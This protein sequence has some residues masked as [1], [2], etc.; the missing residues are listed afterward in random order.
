MLTDRPI[1]VSIP[2]ADVAR[3]KRFFAEQ[4][5][6][7]PYSEHQYGVIYHSGGAQITIVGQAQAAGQAQYSLM[8]WL[9]EDIEATVATLRARGV[10]F[11]EYDFD[12]PN[13]HM[14][15]GIA[16]IEED[17]VAW[18]KDSEGNLLA[19]AQMAAD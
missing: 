11:E 9:V 5:G 2:A 1:R 18:F 17:R 3:A 6:L 15:D 7:T 16:T 10:V 12:L 14:E 13:F 19:V 8:T 4:L